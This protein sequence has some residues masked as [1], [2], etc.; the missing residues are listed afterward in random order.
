MTENEN[1]VTEEVVE[2]KENNV[3]EEV[4]EEKEVVLEVK[5]VNWNRLQND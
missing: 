5:E 1:N 4:V 3:T 2:E